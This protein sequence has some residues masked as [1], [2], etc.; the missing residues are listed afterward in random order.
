MTPSVGWIGCGVMGFSMVR[1]LL[2]AGYQ[3]GVHTRTPSRA[4]LL[5]EEGAT[6]VGSGSELAQLHDIVISMVGTPADV[7]TVYFGE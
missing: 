4:K 3:M 6:W 2:T 1:N 5:I 7:E